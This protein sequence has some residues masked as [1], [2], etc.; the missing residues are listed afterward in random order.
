MKPKKI[1]IICK[2]KVD[3]SIR[4]EILLVESFFGDAAIQIEEK[5]KSRLDLKKFDTIKRERKYD[6]LVVF[7]GDGTLLRTLQCMKHFDVPILGVNAGNLGFLSELEV[8]KMELALESIR[9]NRFKIDE[10]MTLEIEIKRK[11]ES[12]KKLK[13]LN[14]IVV[15]QIS[16]ARLMKLKVLSNA[17]HIG[18]YR[19]DGFIVSTPT[20]ATAYSLAAGGPLVHP[21]MPAFILSPICPHTLTQRPLIVPA[22]EKI[23]ILFPEESEEKVSLTVDGQ[24][25]FSLKKE[26]KINVKK[27]K[28]KLKLLRLPG[29]SY[30]KTLRKKLGWGMI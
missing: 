13:A 1:G 29:S 20:G 17:K 14:E 26:D 28:K 22:E 9:Q 19:A 24:I 30:F 25:Y 11:K 8:K 21:G 4:K 2:E 16:I 10:R 27:S 7:G 12:I 5:I 6:L 18:N 3:K 23:S 15:N